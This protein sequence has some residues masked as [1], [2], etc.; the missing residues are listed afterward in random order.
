MSPSF[1]HLHL[2]SEY[3]LTDSTLRIAPLVKR[4]A[5]LGQPAV[6]VTDTSNLFALVK[7]FKA[8]EGAGLKPIAG[9]DLY[10]AEDNEPGDIW[11][12]ATGGEVTST[13]VR[14]ASLRDCDAE[15]TGI[16][17]DKSGWTL[18]VQVQHAGWEG[19]DDLTV[20]IRKD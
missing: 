7:F 9:A 17:F 10:V 6:A 12:A 15:P 5:E 3:S 20:T 2:H 16:Y 18:F 4:C 14:F 8:A 1:V 19:G 11:V 13:V